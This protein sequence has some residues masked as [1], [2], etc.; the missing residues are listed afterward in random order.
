MM[1][2]PVLLVLMALVALV[3]GGAVAQADDTRR[4]QQNIQQRLR[5]VDA[6]VRT[7][8]TEQRNAEFGSSM[9]HRIR[10]VEQ[11]LQRE[12]QA[13]RRAESELRWG[14]ADEAQRQLDDYQRRRQATASAQ[15]NLATE[16]Q[17]SQQFGSRDWHATRRAADAFSRERSAR[18]PFG[19]S[20]RASLDAQIRALEQRI[21]GL[22]FGSREWWAARRQLDELRRARSTAR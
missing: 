20:Y 22:Q 2:I 6:E 3:S 14:R 17:R 10:S 4:M 7:L 5:V 8:Q 15:R 13:L 9:W 11:A 16:R 21:R 12:K 18:E 19:P 1:R